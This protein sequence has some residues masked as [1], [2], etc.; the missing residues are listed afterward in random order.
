M[1]TWPRARVIGQHDRNGTLAVRVRLLVVAPRVATAGAAVRMN[2]RQSRESVNAEV[3]SRF[4]HR[5]GG[6]VVVPAVKLRVGDGH[7]GDDASGLGAHAVEERDVLHARHGACELVE[8]CRPGSLR[9]H[10]H[11]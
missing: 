11:R 5:L 10:D 3:P 2:L 1:G 8:E 7:G 9:D 6:D 4:A